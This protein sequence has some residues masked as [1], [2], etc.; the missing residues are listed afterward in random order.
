[1]VWLSLSCGKSEADTPAL[2]RTAARIEGDYLLSRIDWEGDPVD[3]NGDGIAG[4]RLYPEMMSLPMIAGHRFIAEVVVYKPERCTG[5][6][7]I[8]FPI[9]N[10]SATYFGSYPVEYMSGGVL[11][12]SIPFR[13]EPD[14]RIITESFKSF[15]VPEDELRVEIKNIHEGV[16]EFDDAGHLYFSACYTFYDRLTDELVSGAIKYTYTKLNSGR[17]SG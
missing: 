16:A 11:T 12:V 14:G 5:G 3:I 17:V 8:P 15:Q 2:S 1:M 7:A 9:Q 6:I 4:N 13:I 10:S